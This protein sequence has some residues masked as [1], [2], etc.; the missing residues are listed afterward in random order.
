MKQ[1]TRRDATKADRT[2]VKTISLPADL[3]RQVE[4]KRLQRDPELDFSKYVR[5]LLRRDLP[6]GVAA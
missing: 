6:D 3:Y 4:R 1:K 5:A 2:I